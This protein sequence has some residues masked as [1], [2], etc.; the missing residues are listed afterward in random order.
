V[1]TYYIGRSWESLGDRVQA[2]EKYKLIAR[3]GATGDQADYAKRRL[4]EWGVVSQTPQQ[5]SSLQ[6]QPYPR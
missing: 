4:V 6:Q 1:T 5:Q 3:S 2:A